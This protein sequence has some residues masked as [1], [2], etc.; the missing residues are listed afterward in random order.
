MSRDSKQVLTELLVY[1]SQG[2]DE[3]AFSDLFAL[4]APSF[5]RFAGSVLKNDQGAEEAAQETW[6]AIARGIGKL[7]DPARFRAWAFRVLRRRCADWVRGRE[8][9]RKRE[10]RLGEWS[11]AEEES[12]ARREGAAPAAMAELIQKLDTDDRQLLL[13][14]YEQGLSVGE[15]SEAMGIPAGTVKSRLFG[16]RE[17]L[18]RKL[19]RKLKNE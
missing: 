13:L 4:W 12:V 18:R 3:E 9:E 1:K 19:E 15:V 16:L 6:V 10:A 2:G 5:L 17:E 8:R 14:F 7:D 11:E